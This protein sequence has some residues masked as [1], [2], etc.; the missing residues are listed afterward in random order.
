MIIKTVARDTVQAAL[1][2]ACR[3]P[4]VHNTQPWRWQVTDRS[5]QLR[6]DMNRW[7]PATDPDG[8]DMLLSCGAWL[9][10]LRVALASLNVEAT[11]HRLPDPAEP[12]L[13][14]VIDI[15]P[16]AGASSSVAAA[17]Q[18][19]VIGRRRTDRR[20]FV[21][22]HV[23]AAFLKDLT[24]CAAEQGALLRVVTDPVA[25]DT[26]AIAIRTAVVEHTGSSAY[27]AELATWSG[28]R[29]S[30]DG[31]AVGSV[32]APGR[33][34]DGTSVRRFA[35]GALVDT[36][37]DTHNVATLLVLGTS[38]DDALSQLRA[39]EAM[40]AVLLLATTQGL[41]SSPFSEPLEVE[42][43][44]ALLRDEVLG[45]TLSPQMVLRVGWPPATGP[46]PPKSARL[47]SSDRS[48]PLG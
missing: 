26:L 42:G 8:R 15:Q 16:G 39:G 23:P 40:S 7:L 44:R 48:D 29:H 4:S 5:I 46:V 34:R 19:A 10:H 17:E 20:R 14:A 13:L 45:G 47:S 6:A 21:N 2:L 27:D 25:L 12:D 22:W 3:A 37:A 9:H 33:H 43:T 41:G 30:A 24:D 18:A 35:G 32:P 36:G 38:S 1:E 11:V 31:V 28:R